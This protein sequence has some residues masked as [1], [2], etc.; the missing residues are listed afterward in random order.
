MLVW[1]ASF[2]AA[3]VRERWSIFLDTANKTAQN[4]SFYGSGV[5]G[6]RAAKSPGYVGVALPRH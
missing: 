3:V 4:A 6:N 1:G 2:R 5:S